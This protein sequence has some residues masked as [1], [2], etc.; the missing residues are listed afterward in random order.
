MS[1]VSRNSLC[2]CGSNKK[3]KRCCENKTKVMNQLSFERTIIGDTKNRLFQEIKTPIWRKSIKNLPG[4]IK[5][6]LKEYLSNEK[7]VEYGCYYNSSHLTLIYPEIK[8]VQ[9]WYGYKTDDIYIKNVVKNFDKRFYSYC[10]EYGKEIIDL[11]EKIRYN[12]HS[13]NEY[14]GI[15]FD[16]STEQNETFDEW[17]TYKISEIKEFREIISDNLISDYYKSEIKNKKINFIIRGRK[18]LNNSLLTLLN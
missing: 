16:L 1:T 18:I 3:F 13:W 6:I 7:I 4:N 10:D 15:Y 9:G 5:D 14:N 11:K 2:P 17:I 8:T 12:P